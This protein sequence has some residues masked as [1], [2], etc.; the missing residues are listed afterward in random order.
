MRTRS[1]NMIV[2]ASFLAALAVGSGL[3]TYHTLAAAVP[4]GAERDGEKLKDLLVQR[5]TLAQ[6]E[7]DTWK[8]AFVQCQEALDSTRARRP[9]GFGD[10]NSMLDLERASARVAKS[11]DE[12]IQWTLHLHT[13]EL[14][15]AQR[16]AERIAAWE[17]HAKRMKEVEALFE[18]GAQGY[19]HDVAVAKFHRLSA[20]IQLERT[21]TE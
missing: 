12:L 21:R 15:L 1:R 11:H 14:E 13:A 10:Q 6:H 18:Q 7:F 19:T 16:R 5:R 20:E 17:T 8:K 2:A 3:W 4:A 9:S